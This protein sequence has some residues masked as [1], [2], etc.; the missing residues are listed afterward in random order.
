MLTYAV[1]RTQ[2][3]TVFEDEGL[4]RSSVIAA[5]V[6]APPASLERGD[7]VQVCAASLVAER[8][9]HP[10]SLDFGVAEPGGNFMVT[11][12]TEHG[13]KIY[14]CDISS[15][16]QQATDRHCKDPTFDPMM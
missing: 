2:L 13:G 1:T 3:S 9:I 6:D 12:N 15:P 11:G 14:L 4:R 8:G 7:T 10:H 5:S 16:Q